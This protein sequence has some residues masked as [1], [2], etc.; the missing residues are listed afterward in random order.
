MEQ[1]ATVMGERMEPDDQRHSP[2]RP[3]V[4]KK[5]TPLDRLGGMCIRNAPFAVYLFD[6]E[7]HFIDANPAGEQLLGYTRDELLSLCIMDVDVD[8]EAVRVAHARL[9]RG[10]PLVNFEHRLRRKDGHAIHV[11]NH[12][13]VLRNSQGKITHWCSFLM[14]ITEQRHA[15]IETAHLAAA[16]EY[17]GEAM[18]ICDLGM[19]ISHVNPAFER[20]TGYVSDEAVGRSASILHSD[21]QP[22]FETMLATVSK[23]KAW[24]GEITIL[25]KDGT[26]RDIDRTIAPVKDHQGNIIS[27]VAIC[28]DITERKRIQTRLEES[29]ARYRSLVENMPDAI[30]VHHKGRI[31]FANKSASRILATDTSENLIG[32]RAIQFV[33]PDDRSKVRERIRQALLQGKAQ[34][35]V[36]IRMQRCDGSD[37]TAQAT[38]AP[39][40]YGNQ[41]AIQ[42]VFRDITSA[43]QKEEAI[44][45]LSKENSR[46][47]QHM[48]M[49]VE[50]ER[51]HFARELHDELGQNLSL[52]KTEI[53][54]AQK[55]TWNRKE[56]ADAI[57]T[58]DATTDR[59][60]AATRSMFQR[61]RPDILDHASLTETLLEFVRQWERQHG[62]PCAFTA[63]GNLD[64][65]DNDTRLALYRLLQEGLTNVARH[66][67]ASHVDGYWRKDS[68]TV[69]FSI[70]DNGRGLPEKEAH[71]G[72]GLIGMRERVHA[73]RGSFTIESPAGNGVCIRATIPLERT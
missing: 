58:I 43:K 49:A 73:L 41:R 26:L 52:V 14:D 60:I 53:G 46:L 1:E 13:M 51:Q 19:R 30:I 8:P 62:I 31:V 5:D 28:R 24:H 69:E 11:R 29:E 70:R 42:V 4:V 55:R 40:Q 63:E 6:A 2:A 67:R 7:Q 16:F 10:E 12:S 34:S 33:H 45:R 68:A 38:G 35:L 9:R 48:I 3:D 36:E 54:R 50:R 44:L 17:A 21:K 61:L 64:D 37:F 32:K 23:G 56:L 71:Q 59:V 47:A 57:R 27:H 65:L 20:L 25:C 72:L 15:E 22:F 66:A 18:F 39:V